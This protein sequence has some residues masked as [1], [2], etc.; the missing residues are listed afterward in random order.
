M[1][2]HAL[3]GKLNSLDNLVDLFFQLNKPNYNDFFKNIEETID[4]ETADELKGKISNICD[5]Y[6]EVLKIIEGFKNFINN[7]KSLTRKDFAIKLNSSYGGEKNNR[8]GFVF[9]LYDGRE[10]KDEQI[11]KILFQCLKN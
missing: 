6:K 10:L 3:K 5:S 2:R 9:W 7:N 8:A 4:W 1:F 11:K